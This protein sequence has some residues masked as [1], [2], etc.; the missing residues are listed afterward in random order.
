MPKGIAK[1][2]AFAGGLLVPV[3][4]LVF[5]NFAPELAGRDYFRPTILLF[6]PEH[7]FSAFFLMAMA[8][9]IMLL[10]F[11][12]LRE[13][14]ILL[15][16]TTIMCAIAYQRVL[17]R[18][19]AGAIFLQ[20]VTK[21]INEKVGVPTLNDLFARLEGEVKAGKRAGSPVSGSELPPSIQNLYRSVRP[22]GN[23]DFS[24][25]EVMRFQIFWGGPLLRWGI[26][27]NNVGYE[28][29]DSSRYYSTQQ[30]NSNIVV[31]IGG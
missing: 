24:A 18:H 21:R 7:I 6:M 31:F 28:L 20:T 22:D 26:Y 10:C 2:S 12:Q 15:I 17:A 25:G 11:R 23:L 8:G 30:L 9:L 4:L 3:A 14:A 5:G 16:A 29:N 19:D 27:M 1:A 13:P